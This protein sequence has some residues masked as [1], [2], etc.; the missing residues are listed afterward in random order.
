MKEL[1][2]GLLVLLDGSCVVIKAGATEAIASFDGA[3][4]LYAAMPFT[5][6]RFITV[7]F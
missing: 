2:L 4:E 3:P 5:Y 6:I 1:S 7:T